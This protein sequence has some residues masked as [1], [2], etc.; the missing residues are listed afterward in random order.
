M[1]AK[2]A[3]EIINSADQIQVLHQGSPIWIEKVMENNTA[4]I[5]HMD[6][7]R[8]ETVPVYMLIER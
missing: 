7:N 6:G 3:K 4:E 8:K 5:R 2:R 1:D